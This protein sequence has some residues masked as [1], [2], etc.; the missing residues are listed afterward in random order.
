MQ[1]LFL[2]FASLSGFLGVCLGAFAA[3]G[4]KSQISAE[5]LA[6]WQTG[7]H[8]Q[9]YHAFALLLVGLLYPQFASKAL[10]LSGLAFI[11][12]TVLFSGSLYSLAL[13]A[14][15]MVGLVTPIGGVGFLL[16][17]LLLFVRV[18]RP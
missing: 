6:V 1:R 12:G 3:H 18:I 5:S 14:P 16:G 13:G 8:Y 17:W 10:K 7:V 2:S 15:K 9:M 11:L 4:L